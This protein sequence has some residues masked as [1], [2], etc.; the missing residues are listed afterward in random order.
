MLVRVKPTA[1]S[2]QLT[3][4]AAGPAPASCCETQ[5]C[6]YMGITS[7]GLCPSMPTRQQKYGLQWFSDKTGNTGG[8]VDLS[9]RCSEGH[10]TQMSPSRGRGDRPL[11]LL[12]GQDRFLLSLAQCRAST[13][14]QGPVLFCVAVVLHSVTVIPTWSQSGP[15]PNRRPT[16]E[17]W[18]NLALR[19]SVKKK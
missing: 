5:P 10:G 4:P 6:C 8:P 13:Q 1:S 18:A 17:H 16:A 19:V 14:W 3:L 7:S 12:P 15:L 9:Y 11:S 2:R